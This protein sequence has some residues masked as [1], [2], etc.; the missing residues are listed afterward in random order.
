MALLLPVSL[1]ALAVHAAPVVSDL[2]L[3]PTA[4]IDIGVL[5]GVQTAL[6]DADQPV[7]KYLGIPFAVSPPERFSRPQPAA[8]LSGPRN[9]TAPA[10]A[11]IQQFSYPL[12]AA[13][14]QNDVFNEPE[15]P[16]SEDCLYTNVYAPAGPSA[17][18]G[19]LPVLFWIYG[20][21]LQFGHAGLPEYDG[22]AFAAYHDVIVV[23]SNYRTNVFGFSHSPQ[24]DTVD[25]N[26]GAYDIRLALDWTKRNIAAFGGDPDKITIFGESAGA[27]V[28]DSF[29]TTYTDDNAPFRGAILESTQR[30]YMQ[31]ANPPDPDAGWDQLA[32]CLGCSNTSTQLACVRAAPATQIKT[33]IETQA[34]SFEPVYDNM[35]LLLD[36]V[37][38]RREGRFVH[39]PIMS[40][41]NRDEGNTFVLNDLNL[42]SFLDQQIGVLAPA[43]IPALLAA[44]PLTDYLDPNADIANIATYL[45]FQCL[46]AMHLNDTIAQHVPAWRYFYDAHFPNV[47]YS[48]S[49]GVYHSSEIQSL[50]QSY[51]G[52]PL[53]PVTLQPQ[54]LIRTDLPPTPQQQ[55]LAAFMN[56]AWAAFAKNPTAGPGWAEYSASGGEI[57][58]LGADGSASYVADNQRHLDAKCPLF[59]PQYRGANPG[60]TI[61]DPTWEA[62]L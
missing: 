40:G 4:T 14:F 11:C 23:G 17:L 48:N 25:Q 27:A 39:V 41:N 5:H 38:A 2:P 34:L 12:A 32:A 21:G 61:P 20:G 19:S 47:A 18:H 29:L 22:A 28:V 42:L 13:E 33:I 54:G 58:R 36:P 45:G 53:N 9:V 44:F 15:S 10:P 24:I 62:F 43:S 35:T 3:A 37:T 60:I 1:L 16:E 51:S 57:A 50:F 46:L 30:S 59:W 6:P 8:R 55:Q 7:N 52:G 31:T 49:S 56:A 26:V